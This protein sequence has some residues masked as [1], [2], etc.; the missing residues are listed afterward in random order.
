MLVAAVDLETNALTIGLALDTG[1]MPAP[2]PQRPSGDPGEGVTLNLFKVDL[3]QALNLPWQPRRYNVA[4]LLREFL[5]N[6]VTVELAYDGAPRAGV[7]SVK[8]SQKQEASAVHND[9]HRIYPLVN[10][11]GG[12]A[13]Q[14]D[15]HRQELSPPIPSKPGIDFRIDR[16][17][18][19]GQGAPCLLHG[20]FRLPVLS[21]ELMEPSGGTSSQVTA[22]LPITLVVTGSD[23]TGPWVIRLQVPSYDAAVVRG[24]PATATG[25]FAFDLLQLREFPRGATTYFLSAFNGEFVAGPKPVTLVSGGS[26]H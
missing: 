23:V 21:R 8:S 20:S 17:V 19:L 12:N 13:P 26:P 18:R 2:R 3:R 7:G 11:A 9:A 4:V 22:I 10:P 14:P 5:S 16:T 15:Y 25:Y 24:A 6:P 1:K